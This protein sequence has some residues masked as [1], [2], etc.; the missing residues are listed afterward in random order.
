[1]SISG[2]GAYDPHALGSPSN[3]PCPVLE[4]DHLAL[5]SV[6][7]LQNAVNEPA[8]EIRVG[9]TPTLPLAVHLDEHDIIGRDLPFRPSPRMR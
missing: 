8:H 1:L 4:D 5:E 6:R 9:R 3:A 2:Q 7:M